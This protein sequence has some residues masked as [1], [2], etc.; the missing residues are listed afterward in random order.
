MKINSQKRLQVYFVFF[1]FF[2]I[3]DPRVQGFLFMDN[4]L[5]TIGLVLTYLSCVLVIGP[6]WMRDRKPFNINSILVIYNAFQVT[7]S[8]YMF[9]EVSFDKITKKNDIVKSKPTDRQSLN[10]QRVRLL[11]TFCNTWILYCLMNFQFLFDSISWPVG[12]ITTA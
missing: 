7:L 11:L 12:W 2:N 1:Y 8:A 9:Y 4:P 6:L 3:P 10:K 5:P